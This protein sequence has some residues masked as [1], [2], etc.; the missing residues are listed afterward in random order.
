MILL[1]FGTRP[2]FIKIKPIIDKFKE[3]KFYDYKLLFTG[4]HKEIIGESL[5]FD[6]KIEIKDGNN[7]LNDIFISILQND[8]FLNGID[9]VLVQGDTATAYAVALCAFHK[10]IP[11]VHLEAGLRTYDINNPYPEEY[12]R[13]CISNLSSINL[14][15]S[16]FG[17]KNLVLEKAPGL[18]YIIGNTVLDNIKNIKTCY[19]DKVLVTLHRRENHNIIFKW[20]EEIEK[21]ANKYSNIEF[22][23]PIH[24]NPDVKKYSNILKKVKVVEPLEHKDLISYLSRTKF[25]ITDSGGLQEES[26][27]LKKKSIVCRKFTERIE[28]LDTFSFLCNKP[29]NLSK[30]VDDLMVSYEI[31]EPCP[32]GD[33]NSSEKVYEILKRK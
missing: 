30:M 1:A 14:C 3:K 24:P 20:F 9:K 19:E 27:F 15:V 29:E 17:L 28:G 5:E 8:S 25:I 4:Q 31:E 16:K 26:S 33:G 11:V 10:K 32:Y 23:L 6:Y 2:E 12:Y 22:L 21:I 7:R 13:R 18:N